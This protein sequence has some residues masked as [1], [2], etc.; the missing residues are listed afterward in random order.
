MPKLRSHDPQ[1]INARILLLDLTIEADS[2]LGGQAVMLRKAAYTRPTSGNAYDE[3]DI[4]FEGEIVERITVGHPKTVA[5]KPK[6]KDQ[7]EV[8]PQGREEIAG[9]KEKG[10]EEE[11]QL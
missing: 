5:K 7:Q 1:G 11:E 3:V 10:R 6:K 9:E 4:L 8:R 2:G